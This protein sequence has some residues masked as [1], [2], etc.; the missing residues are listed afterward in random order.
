[1]T[2]RMYEIC[3]TDVGVVNLGEY[4]SGQSPRIDSE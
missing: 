3:L 2:N 1:M 4:S